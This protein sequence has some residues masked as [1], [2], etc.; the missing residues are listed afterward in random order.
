LSQMIAIR[1]GQGIGAL[2]LLEHRMFSFISLYW[3]GKPLISH[4]VGVNLIGNTSAATG[5]R[6]QAELDTAMYPEGVKVSADDLGKLKLTRHDF[7]G[8]WNYSIA[9]HCSI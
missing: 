2:D 1:F 5:L 6:I 3:R 4:E 8:E 9:P 7:H